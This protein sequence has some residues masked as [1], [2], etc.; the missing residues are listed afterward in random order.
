MEMKR[1]ST[2]INMNDLR[3]FF[4]RRLM[5]YLRVMMSWVIMMARKRKQNSVHTLTSYVQ[6]NS[7]IYV[8]ATPRPR[9]S[10][11]TRARIQF[12]RQTEKR[13][14]VSWP[15]SLCR[16]EVSKKVRIHSWSWRMT[17]PSSLTRSQWWSWA[18]WLRRVQRKNISSI[19][20][21]TG[22]RRSRRWICSK[23]CANTLSNDYSRWTAPQSHFK[24]IRFQ[25]IYR[26]T[27]TK[28]TQ[29]IKQQ[30]RSFLEILVELSPKI[31]SKHPVR[32]LTFPNQIAKTMKHWGPINRRGFPQSSSHHPKQRETKSL[33]SH[34]KPLT[35]PQQPLL[36][37]I[38][39]PLIRGKIN[40]LR[41]KRRALISWRSSGTTRSGSINSSTCQMRLWCWRLREYAKKIMIK[42]RWLSPLPKDEVLCL[43]KSN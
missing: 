38:R 31:Y 42:K 12:T 20:P 32:T 9:W 35:Y 7:K 11:F 40:W 13:G 21:R 43:I 30:K 10:P 5:T 37:N 34:I 18:R 15:I 8:S 33:S 39:M 25:N 14:L 16:R 28:L 4:Q 36:G 22:T 1:E 29:I 3:A 26:R 27:R 6:K 2:A 17:R 41:R 19:W 24:M 23:F